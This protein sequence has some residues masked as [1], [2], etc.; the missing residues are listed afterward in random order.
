MDRLRGA[1]NLRLRFVAH[2]DNDGVEFFRAVDELGL[3]G[4]VCKQARSVYRPASAAP[5]G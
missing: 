4:I 5:I 2:A 1:D 3:E